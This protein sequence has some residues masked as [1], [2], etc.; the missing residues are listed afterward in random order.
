ML[1]EG[2]LTINVK[3]VDR[4]NEFDVKVR[5]GRGDWNGFSFDVGAASP[6]VAA[7]LWRRYA[8]TGTVF[9]GF[10]R[11]GKDRLKGDPY[12]NDI[13]NK[14]VREA[15]ANRRRSLIDD[16]IRYSADKMY[17]VPAGGQALG[18]RLVWPIIQNFGVFRA[19]IPTQESDVHIWLDQTKPP[20]GAS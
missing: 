5:R 7:F 10:D 3:V 11:D 12:I 13:T 9:A 8:N 15:D 2:G 14:M 6:S 18:F 16:F 17:E 20:V 4:V 1:K 19:I